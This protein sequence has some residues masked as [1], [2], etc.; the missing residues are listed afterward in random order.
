M[1]RNSAT[2]IAGST[3]VGKTLLSAHFLAAGAA[4]GEPG[5]MCSFFE[6]AS[7]VIARAARVG[8]DLG[9]ARDE[10]LVGVEYQPPLEW[11]ADTVVERILATVRARKVKRL[12]IDSIVG[13]EQ[14]LVEKTR[15]AS[16][17]GALV[18]A[19]RDL[20]VTTLMTKEVSKIAGPELDFSDTPITVVIENFLF[21][22]FVELRGRLH[23]IM[24]VLKMRDSS[25]DGDVREFTIG[26]SGF[27]VL[28]RVSA[29]E[30]LLTSMARAIGT[31]VAPEGLKP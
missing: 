23:R 13:V 8:L 24:S 7:N 9:R 15:T 25:Y 16:F 22:R 28:A 20:D 29:A 31:S 19:L 1:P 18:V 6:P 30:G 5:L 11:E 4:A 3:G 17:L 10:G 21:L 12:V 27:E 14:T 2:L 26:E